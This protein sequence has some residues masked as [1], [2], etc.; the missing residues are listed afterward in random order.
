MPTPIS[1]RMSLP[2]TRPRV[3]QSLQYPGEHSL[4]RLDIDQATRARNRRVIWRRFRQDQPQKLAQGKRIGRPSGDGAL[5]VQTFEVM[6]Q[7]A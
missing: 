6:L 5:G 3:R 1:R 2:F 7:R 4:V